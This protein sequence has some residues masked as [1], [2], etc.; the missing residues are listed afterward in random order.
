MKL[1]LT[2]QDVMGA[3]F[4]FTKSAR[5]SIKISKPYIVCKNTKIVNTSVEKLNCYRSNVAN[6]VKIKDKSVG[7]E[8]S[9]KPQ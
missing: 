6:A 7:S 4:K 2:S 8:F 9:K 5:M 3:C 1:H